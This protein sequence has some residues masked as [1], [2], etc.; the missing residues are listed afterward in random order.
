[1]KNR[2][3][4]PAVLITLPHHT[5]HGGVGNIYKTIK[6][7]KEDKITYFYNTKEKK[8]G[9]IVFFLYML[10]RFIVS[11]QKIGIVHLNPSLNPKAIFRDGILLLLAK[12]FR[13]KVIIFFHGWDDVFQNVIIKNRLYKWVFS[14]IFNKADCFLLLGEIFLN[15]L[16]L[17]GINPEKVFYLPTIAD[18]NLLTNEIFHDRLLNNND[19]HLLFIA[20]FVP[21]KGVDIVLK[22]IELLNKSEDF[23]FKLTMVGDGPEL[24]KC[25]RFVLEKDLKNVIFTGYIEG[26]QKHN[27]LANADILFLPSL[28][29]GLPCVIMEGM[30]YGLAI[31]TRPIGG[32]PYWVKHNLNGWLTE[33]I[34]PKTFSNGIL[35]LIRDHKLMY[36][37]RRNNQRTAIENFTPTKVKNK[38]KNIYNEL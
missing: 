10:F 30:L 37:I 7:N 12:V 9:D 23:G 4:T 26:I 24:E 1:M 18:D 20:G 38:L 32:I 29:E 14:I 13:K 16:N 21:S 11:I 27:C 2:I 34:D 36:N 28:S 5:F 8:S 19:I 3:N 33:S 22:T 17:L 6:W 35:L 31:V 25:K 15:K